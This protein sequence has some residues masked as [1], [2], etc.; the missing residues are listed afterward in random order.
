LVT[1]TAALLVFCLAAASH[2]PWKRFQNLRDR[3][4]L[5]WNIANYQAADW[6]NHNLPEGAI[7]GAPDAGVLGYF[8]N[9]RVVNS[10]GLVGSREYFSAVTR[11]KLHE[12]IDRSRVTHVAVIMSESS[13]DGC[14]AFAS[15]SGQFG[16]FAGTC[17]VLYEG[18]PFTTIGPEPKRVRIFRYNG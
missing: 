9:R 1:A 16:A 4:T 7:V 2:S 17:V 14:R 12:W 5:D 8:V 3:E 11:Q 15:S 6:M 10:D 18:P 13:T